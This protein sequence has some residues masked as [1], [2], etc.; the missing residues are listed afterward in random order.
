MRRNPAA[1]AGIDGSGSAETPA[2][3]SGV[4]EGVSTGESGAQLTVS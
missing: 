3:P 4:T 2:G 1:Y